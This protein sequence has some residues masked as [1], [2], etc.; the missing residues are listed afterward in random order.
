[1]TDR[2]ARTDGST[3]HAC[4][5]TE[6]IYCGGT[7]TGLIDHLDYI[8]NMG[9]D[10]IMISP[11]SEQIQS[12]TYYG[13]P[14]HGYWPTDFYNT[15]SHFGTT[16][17]INKLAT[18]LHD[19]GMYLMIDIV[20]ND[21]AYNLN[22]DDLDTVD[23]SILIPFNAKDDYHSYCAVD[24]SNTTSEEFCNL[25]DKYV[26]LLDLDTESD[27]VINTMTAWTK[28]LIANYSVDGLR[29]DAAKHVDPPFLKNISDAAGIYAVGEVF[30]EEPYNNCKYQPYVPGVTNYPA[31]YG[32]LAA[33]TEGNIT[34]LANVVAEYPQYCVDTTL[35]LSFSENHDLPR[36]ASFTEDT[37]VSFDLMM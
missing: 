10:S 30:E 27:Y 2:F 29:I 18:A 33:F 4:N 8:Q 17:D 21:M 16:D 36:F 26:S 25:G 11:V 7:Y 13:D 15:N 9:F 19:R 12:E 37:A 31:Y 3:T 23:Y 32:M 28:D 22:G 24:Y 34:D 6:G 5:T 14:Y 35:T 1:M 20:I